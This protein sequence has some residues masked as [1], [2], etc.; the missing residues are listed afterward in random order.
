M[1]TR[2]PPRATRG[3]FGQRL[4]I[5]AQDGRDVVPQEM[6]RRAGR[7][8]QRW[9]LQHGVVLLKA[10]REGTPRAS[11]VSEYLPEAHRAHVDAVHTR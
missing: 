2:L 11:D 3:S 8:L 7:K 6:V 4:V 10:Q 1:W 9:V 5:F